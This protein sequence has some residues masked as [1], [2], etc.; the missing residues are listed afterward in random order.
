MLKLFLKRY[1][2]SNFIKDV[3]K[4]I[5]GTV[6]AQSIPILISPL[7][8]RIYTPSDFGIYA[9]Y[10]SII[11]IIGVI[12]TG[13][14]ELAIMLPKKNTE[15]INIL[16]LSITLSIFTSIIT[17]FLIYLFGEYLS[18]HLNN[19]SLYKWL[20][21]IPPGII[22]LGTYQAL[23]YWNNRK[24]KYGTIAKSNIYKGFTIGV[25]NLSWVSISKGPGGLIW[26]H[27]LS[28]FS[29][30]F[31]LLMRVIKEDRA[32]FKTI[33]FADIKTQ[34][35]RYKRFPL[36]S[37]WSALFNSI[38]IQVPIFL[39]SYFFSE[40]IVGFYSFAQRLIFMPMNIIGVSIGQVF[41]QKAVSYKDDPEKL[42]I[43]TYNLFKKLFLIGVLPISV[44]IVFGDYIFP[45]AFGSKWYMAGVYSQILGLWI[46]F[47]FIS[48]PLGNLFSVFE[49]QK[50][51]MIYN[52]M[53]LLS[54]IIALLIGGLYFKD[55]LISVQLFGA[56]GAIFW[57]GY[58]FYLLNL[59]NIKLSTS[60]TFT[61]SRL[62]LILG[63]LYLIRILFL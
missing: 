10:V 58:T 21:L 46:F 40:S 9:L 56:V 5:T 38:S 19:K 49:K 25:V 11:S 6:I 36:F 62:A 60:I 45:L 43:I 37:T 12:A 31:F 47:V 27:F 1:S 2:N 63:S 18:I 61:L 50:E 35:K 14:Y 34:A 28:W 52:I 8:S 41:F 54:R 55:A 7:L 16:V 39:M 26:G 57:G 20:Y 15:A 59:V 4:L 23:S 3:S 42:K 29:A 22:F 44:L 53:I 17:F 33:S 13:R 32:L 51:G 24:M 48:S 30:A